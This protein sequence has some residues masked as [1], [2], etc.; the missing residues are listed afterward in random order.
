MLWL[1]SRQDSIV[2]SRKMDNVPIVSRPVPHY[3]IMEDK[4]KGDFILQHYN[5]SQI[6]WSY[7]KTFPTLTSAEQWVLDGIKKE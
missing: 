5:G 6:G 4:V 3:K 7:V 2:L 1:S